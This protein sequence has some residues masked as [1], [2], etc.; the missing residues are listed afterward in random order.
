MSF[1][2]LLCN[3]KCETVKTLMAFFLPSPAED[4]KPPSAILESDVLVS[5]SFAVP[6]AE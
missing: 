2:S 3:Y 6:I 5:T 1:G 4:K